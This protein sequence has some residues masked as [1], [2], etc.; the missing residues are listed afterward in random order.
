M[1]ETDHLTFPNTA[2]EIKRKVTEEIE[3]KINL[4]LARN[5]RD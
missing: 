1:Q 5:E 2:K 4:D 3:Q